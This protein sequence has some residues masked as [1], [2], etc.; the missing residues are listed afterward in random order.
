MFQ[1]IRRYATKV[2]SPGT[3]KRPVQGI[4]DKRMQVVRD[5]LYPNPVNQPTPPA[6]EVSVESLSQ[7]EII[8]RMWCHIKT[9]EAVATEERLARKYIRMRAAME[10]LKLN[11]PDLFKGTGQVTSSAIDQGETFPRRLRVPTETPPTSGWEY[12]KKL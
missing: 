5:I 2:A 8:E 11:H 6:L 7:R 3:K 12:E 10:E 1:H 4:T 9:K